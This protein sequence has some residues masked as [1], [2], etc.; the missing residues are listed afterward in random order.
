M[1]LVNVIISGKRVFADVI[2]TLERR[3]LLWIIQVGPKCPHKRSYKIEAEGNNRHTEDKA[4]GRQSRERC[5]HQPRNADSCQQLEEIR[6]RFS[7][8]S[9]GSSAQPTPGFWPLAS[10]FVRK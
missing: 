3:R 9:R 2:K 10:R 5:Y 8:A 4:I 7:G 6:N 1:E